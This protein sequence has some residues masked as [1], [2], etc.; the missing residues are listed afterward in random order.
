M[1]NNSSFIYFSEIQVRTTP[2][3][4]YKVILTYEDYTLYISSAD[5][6]RIKT[7]TDE[8]EEIIAIILAYIEYIY[9]S[10]NVGSERIHR[11]EQDVID[12]NLILILKD[13]VGEE[14]IDFVKTLKWYDILAIF[15]AENPIQKI[16]DLK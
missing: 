8:S 2:R 4:N 14:V 13:M 5:V 6:E 3:G 10:T 1:N 9:Q 15:N 7:K 16:R 11:L 12:D